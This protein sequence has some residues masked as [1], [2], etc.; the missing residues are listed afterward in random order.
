MKKKGVK[1]LMLQETYIGEDTREIRK[2][3]T[4]FFSRG[5]TRQGREYVGGGAIVIRNDWRKC[6]A[7]IEPLSDRV[8]YLILRGAA[9]QESTIVATDV[10]QAG[11]TMEKKV[12]TIPDKHT[13]EHNLRTKPMPYS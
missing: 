13:N 7:D 3:Y 9:G 12:I 6:I 4:W 5:G 2:E 10:P 1:I 8:M 11:R